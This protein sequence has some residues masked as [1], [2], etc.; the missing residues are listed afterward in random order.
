MLLLIRALGERDV[1]YQGKSAYYWTEQIK[2]QNITASNRARLVLNQEI[3]PHL[4]K[5]MLEDTNDSKLRLAL[6]EKLNDLPGVNI[7]FRP[8]DSRRAD[9]AVA[10][11]EF[12]PPAEPAV[13]ALLQAFQGHDLPVRAPAAISLGKIHSKPEVIVPLLMSYLEV[14]NLKEA[15]VQALGDYGSLS[16]AAIPKLLLLYKVPDKDLHHAVEEALKQIDPAAAVEA[17]V[18]IPGRPAVAP[19]TIDR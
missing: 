6:V 15:A 10:L 4:T 7:F 1:L 12:G 13:P 14:E 18:R 2:S 3:I 17:G 19:R 8:A 9:A 5:T 16:K 11:G